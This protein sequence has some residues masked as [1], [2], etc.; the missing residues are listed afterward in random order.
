MFCFESLTNLLYLLLPLLHGTIVSE[1]RF[2]LIIKT[3]I[4]NFQRPNGRN[5]KESI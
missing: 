2:N 5:I 3:P 4:C 1:N